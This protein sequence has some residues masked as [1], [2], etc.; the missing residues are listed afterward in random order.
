LR[1][2]RKTTLSRT[3]RFFETS[4]TRLRWCD[5]SVFIDGG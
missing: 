4:S 5:R 1:A 3:H 2:D